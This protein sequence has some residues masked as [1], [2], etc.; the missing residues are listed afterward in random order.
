MYQSRR[1]AI[2]PDNEIKLYPWQKQMMNLIQESTLRE[3]I[4]VKGAHGNEGK[5]W[6][7][8]YVQTL[9]GRERVMQLDLISS[10]GNIMQIL[11]KQSLSTLD[12]FLFNDARSGLDETRCYDVLENI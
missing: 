2:E 11:R 7:Q 10:I 8:K 12:T 3:V 5:T 6:F 4:W 1:L 9:L